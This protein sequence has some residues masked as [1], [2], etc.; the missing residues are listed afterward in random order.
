MVFEAHVNVKAKVKK[1]NVQKYVVYLLKVK[2]A[3]VH[4]LDLAI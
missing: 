2:R 1:Q 4:M 3:A